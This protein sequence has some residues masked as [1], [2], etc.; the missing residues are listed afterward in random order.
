[1][2]LGVNFFDIANGYSTGTSEEYL[3]K[4]L[5][6]NPP[7]GV[8]L[9]PI[10]PTITPRT[11]FENTMQRHIP[12]A[13]QTIPIVPR[14]VATKVLFFIIITSY[15]RIHPLNAGIARI[16]HSHIIGGSAV[17]ANTE[18]AINAVPTIL[19]AIDNAQFGFERA[20]GKTNGNADVDTKFGISFNSDGTTTFFAELEKS[21]ASQKEYLEKL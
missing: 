14:I 18:P 3:G 8:T 17:T 12:S 1:M 21:S 13:K 11:I 20:F 9:I 4:A 15:G 7:E 16:T 2:E 5:K 10:I 6:N 19:V